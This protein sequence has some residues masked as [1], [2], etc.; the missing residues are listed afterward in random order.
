MLCNVNLQRKR[1]ELGERGEKKKR[2]GGQGGGNEG[3]GA[4]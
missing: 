2:G 4:N 1:E 3:E